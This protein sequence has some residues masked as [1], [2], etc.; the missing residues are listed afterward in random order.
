MRANDRGDTE[1]LVGRFGASDWQPYGWDALTNCNELEY[2]ECDDR[3][4]GSKFILTTREA[5]GWLNSMERW[6]PHDRPRGNVRRDF[7]VDM[8]NYNRKRVWGVPTY[9]ENGRSLFDRNRL[10]SRYDEQEAEV[11]DYFRDRGDD[12]MVLPCEIPDDEKWGRLCEFLDLPGMLKMVQHRKYEYPRIN[13]Q[14]PDG[15]RRA[16]QYLRREKRILE[17]RGADAVAKFNAKRSTRIA[18]MD[19]KVAKIGAK[20][21]KKRKEYFAKLNASIEE[22]RASGEF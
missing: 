6:W 7:L 15:V 9:D 5:D 8:M 2:P 4:P 13:V 12:L 20:A 21:K 19:A 14:D 22:L 11:M 17:R 3:Y 1:S 18:E 16:K 10:R